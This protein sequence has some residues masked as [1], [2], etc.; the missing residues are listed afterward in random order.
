[1]NTYRPLEVFTTAALLYFAVLFPL[2]LAVRGV[3]G[4]LRRAE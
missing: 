4:R 2:S 3:E 1:V